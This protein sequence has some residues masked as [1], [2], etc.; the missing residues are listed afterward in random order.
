MASDGEW[1]KGGSKILRHEVP[2]ERHSDVAEVDDEA[3]AAIDRHLRTFV[4]APKTVFHELIS[5]VVHIDVHIIEP[6]EERPCYTLVTTGMS[7]R[8][9]TTPPGVEGYEYTELMLSWPADWAPGPLVETELGDEALYWP[10]R[11][12]KGLAR[13]PHSYNTW[14]SYGHTIPNG[15]PPKPYAPNTELCCALILPPLGVTPEFTSSKSG[16]T[17]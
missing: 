5:D 1:S 4:G 12:L 11:L 14:L 17:R 13:L 7:A 15:N 6:S 8:P 2:A 16:L 9:M 10:I 3:L